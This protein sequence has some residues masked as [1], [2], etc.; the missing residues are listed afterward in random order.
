MLMYVYPCFVIC[1]VSKNTVAWFS[2]V[3]VATTSS[4]VRVWSG[5]KDVLLIYKVV[6]GRQQARGLCVELA[7]WRVID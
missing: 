7:G 2:G 3:A 1:V 4:C 5:C 6:Q